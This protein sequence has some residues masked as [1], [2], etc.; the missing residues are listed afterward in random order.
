MDKCKRR[1]SRKARLGCILAIFLFLSHSS[2]SSEYLTE[3]QL[4]PGDVL[5]ISVWLEEDLQRV[6]LIRPDGGISFPLAGD[7]PA[8]GLTVNEVSNRIQDKLA[9]FIPDAQVTVTLQ[10][11]NGNIVYVLGNVN[12]PGA[13]GY[14][15]QIDVLQ[16]LSLAG[17]TNSF[18]SLS[19]IQ[20]LRR[21]NGTLN[22]IPFNYNDLMKGKNLKQNMLLN[23][24]DT[25]VVP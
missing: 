6:T 18:A 23:S 5:F 25:V 10:E 15:K 13:L 20:I 24:G 22:S 1:I 11:I 8:A 12:R 14:N 21:T 17:G 3:Y 9:K 2:W 19:N 7:L 4:Q 16:A